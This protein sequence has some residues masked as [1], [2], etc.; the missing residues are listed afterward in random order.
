MLKYIRTAL[1]FEAF[2]NHENLKGNDLSKPVFPT[3]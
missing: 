2:G 3:T 1:G